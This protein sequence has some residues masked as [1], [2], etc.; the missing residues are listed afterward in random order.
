MG[1]TNNVRRIQLVLA[2]KRV[3]AIRPQ[4]AFL[5]MLGRALDETRC[6][7]ES[8]GGNVEAVQR[9]RERAIDVVITDPGG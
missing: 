4:A 5:D 6:Q 9:V 8:C 3:L 7:V 1:G 2:A